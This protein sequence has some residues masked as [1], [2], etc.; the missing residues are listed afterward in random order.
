MSSWNPHRPPLAS[1]PPRGDY[2]SEEEGEIGGDVGNGTTENPNSNPPS[3]SNPPTATSFDRPPPPPPPPP[4]PQNIRRSSWTGPRR[5]GGPPQFGVHRSVSVGHVARPGRDPSNLSNMPAP[6]NVPAPRPTDPRFRNAGSRSSGVLSEPPTAGGSYS[7]LADEPVRRPSFEDH[8]FRH[9][10]FRREGFRQSG[11]EGPPP[12]RPSEAA[13]SEGPGPFTR[14][15]SP[16]FDGNPDGFR[17]EFRNEPPPLPQPESSFRGG[18]FRGGGRGFFRGGRGRGGRG[19]GVDGPMEGGMGSYYGP[20]G[21]PE[22]RF[23]GRSPAR[24]RFRGRGRGGPIGRGGRGTLPIDGGGPGIMPDD[25]RSGNFHNRSGSHSSIE[26][27]QHLHRDS[28]SRSWST[29]ISPSQGNRRL[30]DGDHLMGSNSS[31]PSLANSQ[32]P[33][34]PPPLTGAAVASASPPKSHAIDTAPAAVAASAAPAPPSEA[35]PLD[36]SAL[37][38]DGDRAEAA[39]QFLSSYLKD[40]SLKQEGGKSLLPDKPVLF[41]AMQ[42]LDTESKEI[43]EK[44]D[45]KQKELEILTQAQ[46]QAQKDEDELEQV[47]AEHQSQARETARKQVEENLEELKQSRLKKGEEEFEEANAKASAELEE[48]IRR[49]RDEMEVQLIEE[50]ESQMTASAEP[51]D[52]EEQEASEKVEK[53][54]QAV[55]KTES[56]LEVIEADLKSKR[57]ARE[58]S[59]SQSGSVSTNDMV[60]KI[61]A[62]NQRKAAEAHSDPFGIYS[63]E[64]T[65][66]ATT[67][68][69]VSE[70]EEIR[71][72]KER[73]TLSEWADLA[74]Q[75]Q[76]LSTAL[77]T[78]PSET[79]FFAQTEEH[80][81]LLEPLIKEYVRDTQT[82]LNNHF[83][84]L[85]EE[86]E[87]RR[88]LYQ[89]W[90]KQRRSLM[91]EAQRKPASALIPRQTNMMI[92]ESG[93]S[94]PP[95]PPPPPTTATSNPYRRARRNNE[96]R[97]EYEQEQIIAELAAK[98]AMD[99]KIAFGG[100]ALPRQIGQ[101][102]RKLVPQFIQTFTSQKIDLEQLERD[103]VITNTW[104]DMEKCIFLD[105]FMQHPKDFR[106]IASF[107]RNKTA[108]D[109]VAY[110]YDSKKTVP[111]KFALKEF[112]MRRKR[113]GNY[114]VWDATIQAAVASGAIV[115]AGKS[116]EKPLVF[117]L[118]ES[119]ETYISNGLHPVKREMLSS[120]EIDEALAAEYIA[121]NE[122]DDIEEE[123]THKRKADALME[124]DPEVRKFLKAESPPP[125]PAVR[126]GARSR[127]GKPAE[128]S[129]GS[130]SGGLSESVDGNASEGASRA[131]PIRSKPQKW[132]A[133]EKRIFVETLEKH[134]RKWDMLAQAVGTKSIGQIKN[135]YYDYKKQAGRVAKLKKPAGRTE[136]SKT[137]EGDDDRK[138]LNEDT[139]Q[140]FSNED[141]TMDDRTSRTAGGADTLEGQSMVEAAAAEAAAF[142]PY[143]T[144]LHQEGVSP[145]PTASLLHQQALARHQMELAAAPSLPDALSESRQQL[146]QLQQLRGV[147]HD[148][149]QQLHGLT[150]QQ[151]REIVLAQRIQ[152]LQQQLAATRSDR[153]WGAT[154]T[155]QATAPQ[156]SSLLEPSLSEEAARL[157]H[158]HSQSQH[159][160]ILSNLLPWIGS[161]ILGGGTSSQTSA[162]AQAPSDHLGGLSDFEQHQLRTLLSLQQQGSSQHAAQPQS[163]H[164]SSLH[165]SL[166][167]SGLMNPS[168]LRLLEQQQQQGSADDVRL[169]LIRQLLGSG[170]STDSGAFRDYLPPR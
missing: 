65:K 140:G 23:G 6:S 108:Q 141:S 1:N 16:P 4:P 137:G 79:P 156:G 59:G 90:Q 69:P 113:R 34:P 57:Q 138:S 30:I 84:E 144:L 132:T 19:R 110:Y 165:D 94:R 68:T 10:P 36:T 134:G 14:N 27:P 86:Y 40:E 150:D 2:D 73:K 12:F 93:G 80:H 130:K 29:T 123:F 9:E 3:S 75:V 78:E 66:Q 8:H 83:T 151:L 148:P 133:T 157:L 35:S 70:L 64:E 170:A 153:D 127:E 111:Y 126:D 105:R 42:K 118:P 47:A 128:S 88:R 7:S 98:E 106:K 85:A 119:D 49:R 169:E 158:H 72:P 46:V 71:D 62:E 143:S 11:N 163:H 89:E 167:L 77:Y 54:S 44:I 33:P 139:S 38:E 21:G 96:V 82:R 87:Y 50:M 37:D 95:Q 161:S 120:L 129:K 159:Q 99:K 67:V 76:G 136:K 147:G 121:N 32:L 112:V 104:S 31:L 116:E 102:E 17:G 51:F 13:L 55:A 63:T 41:R 155:A 45:T 107:L 15:E 166:A 117:L 53:T 122:D 124:V 164:T 18:G 58:A 103:I 24:G 61:L 135:F 114:H 26:R 92:L 149:G 48:E 91:S 146:L 162:A 109:C 145:L 115:K 142:S 81:K 22:D 25:A 154:S 152:D 52:R 56:K 74:R 97:S 39:I 168:T 100:S 5:G 43:Q 28:F 131:T 20:T 125:L 60:E 101:V 160:Q